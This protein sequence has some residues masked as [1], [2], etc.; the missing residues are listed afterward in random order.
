M[1]PRDV[2]AKGRRVGYA[3]MMERILFITSTRIGDAVINSGVLDHLVRTRSNA[4]FTIA[5]GKLAQPILEHTPRLDQ[6]IVVNKKPLGLHWLGLWRRVAGTKWDLVVDMRGS[7]IAALL[8]ADVRK[9]LRSTKIPMHKVREAAGVMRLD[10]PPPPKIHVPEDAESRA[11]KLFPSNRDVLAVCPSASWP[12][13]MWPGDRFGELVKRLVSPGGPMAGALV[14]IFGGP[15]DEVHAKPIHEALPD[16]GVF[17]LTGK[18]YLT[19][20]AAC[21]SR[22][23]LFVGNDSGV[24]HIAAAMG[25]PTLGLFGPSDERLYGPYGEQCAIVRGPRNF[26]TIQN[27]TPNWKSHPSSLLM[28][29]STDTAFEAASRLLERTQK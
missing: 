23:R 18:L 12:F 17:D 28:D 6:I 26:D 3:A 5:C 14:V 13:K 27:E 20:V 25:T 1:D 16:A 21:L 11:A 8:R 24:M 7:A 9:T 29:L 22:A 4:R 10:P 2:L 19:D 15:G